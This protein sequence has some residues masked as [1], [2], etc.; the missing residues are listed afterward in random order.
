MIMHPACF[1]RGGGSEQQRGCSHHEEISEVVL[2]RE[3]I[4]SK[5]KGVW[6]EGGEPLCFKNLLVG[7][8]EDGMGSPSEGVWVSPLPRSQIL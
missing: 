4:T 5:S 1:D 3:I 6:P 7:T 8:S 2:D